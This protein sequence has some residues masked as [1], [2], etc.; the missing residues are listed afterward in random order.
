MLEHAFSIVFFIYYQS[1]PHS[2]FIAVAKTWPTQST[3]IDW[4]FLFNPTNQTHFKIIEHSS[5]NP[6]DSEIKSV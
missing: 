5:S 2:H 4:E 1:F 6:E 3:A